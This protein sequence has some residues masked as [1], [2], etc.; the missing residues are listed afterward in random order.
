M[1]QVQNS[2]QGVLGRQVGSG[3]KRRENKERVRETAKMVDIMCMEFQRSA[4]EGADNGN[5]LNEHTST[6]IDASNE[7]ESSATEMQQLLLTINSL[8][9]KPNRLGKRNQFSK[10]MVIM[11]P[12]LI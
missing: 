5:T 11:N 1:K 9:M 4:E 10:M 2:Y 3:I 8:Q 7:D 6:T 12:V